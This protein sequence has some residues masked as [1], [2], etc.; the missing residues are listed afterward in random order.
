LNIYPDS[1]FLFSRYLTDG[2]SQEVDRRMFQRPGVLLTPFNRAELANAIFQQVFQGRI[3][4]S[5]AR[6]A[7]ADFEQDCSL[8]VWVITRQPEEAFSTCV[9]LV[10]RHAATLGVRTLD[11]LHVAAALELGV[12]RFWTFD[13]RQAQLAEAEGLTTI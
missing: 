3:S 2:H 11:T 1:S 6:T 4:L 8:G 5:D 10:R 7:Y 9:D 12:T 13:Q